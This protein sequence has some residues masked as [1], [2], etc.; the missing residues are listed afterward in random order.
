MCVCVCVFTFLGS[1]EQKSSALEIVRLL[2]MKIPQG[3][4]VHL[5]KKHKSM[6]KAEMPRLDS[7]EPSF[8]HRPL[9]VEIECMVSR[10]FRACCV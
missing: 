5:A 10:A 9:K 7:F 6:P 8:Y 4:Q 2:S 3:S 1:R